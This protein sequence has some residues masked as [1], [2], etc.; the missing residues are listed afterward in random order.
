MQAYNF[1][2]F[3]HQL[4]R[5]SSRSWPT[6]LAKQL[7]LLVSGDGWTRGRQ[8]RSTRFPFVGSEALNIG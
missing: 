3:F 8:A 6:N 2:I 5:V 4:F 7:A 1:S